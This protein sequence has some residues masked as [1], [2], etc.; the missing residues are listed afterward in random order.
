MST[1]RII[2][3]IVLFLLGVAAT[4]GLRTFNKM[5]TKDIESA[6]KISG[7]MTV[8]SFL[9][10]KEGDRAIYTG[11]ISATDPVSLKGE[12]GQY[13]KIKLDHERKERVYNND[14]DK[15]ETTRRTIS[16]ESEKCKE[17]LLDDVKVPYSKVHS[18]PEEQETERSGDDEYIYT[19]TPAVVDGTFYIKCKDGD[20]ES[21]K[22]FESV[23]VAGETSK[24]NTVAIVC[25][26]LILIIISAVIIVT[27]VKGKKGK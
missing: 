12:N 18:L 6:T 25:V 17:L 13:I 8:G 20:I 27:G 7:G 21:V 15:W 22:Y 16:K 9:N 11:S 24:T 10:Q 2:I 3:V 4:A 23:D 5:E 26:W 1:K 14:E 19:Y